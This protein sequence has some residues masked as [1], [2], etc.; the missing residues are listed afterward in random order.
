MTKKAILTTLVAFVLLLAVVAA[1]LNAVFTVTIVRTD[2]AVYSA[3]GRA[4]SAELQEKLDGFVGSSTTFLDLDDL[5]SEVE[6]YPCFRLDRIEKKFPSSVELRVVER[7]EAYAFAREEGGYAILDEDGYYLY[8]KAT[9]GNR[10]G[11]ESVEL[12]DFRIDTARGQVASGRYFNEL[13]L[14]L[15]TFGETLG[16]AR[17]N[18]ASVSLRL[19]GAPSSGIYDFLIRTREGLLIEI[20]DVASDTAEKAA[21]AAETYRDMEDARRVRGTLTVFENAWGE[22]DTDYKL[23]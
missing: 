14:T 4:E 9:R 7:R 1:G 21:L 3:E 13:L 23:S 17:A 16:D 6:N 5:K 10:A 15:A 2:F 22:A 20:A 12:I 8:D 19:G 11:G 18:L